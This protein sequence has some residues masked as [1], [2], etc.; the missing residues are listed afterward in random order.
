MRCP[1]A[2]CVVLL[3]LVNIDETNA[4]RKDEFRCRDLCCI[5]AFAEDDRFNNDNFI[6]AFKD[7]YREI[8]I[9]EDKDYRKYCDDLEMFDE[10]V[11][12]DSEKECK[13]KME[14]KDFEV[15]CEQEKGEE[16]KKCF[17]EKNDDGE[18]YSDKMMK[19]VYEMM[20]EG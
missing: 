7:I 20:C 13:N 18:D 9:D 6:K 3:V 16:F 14:D 19:K 4:N 12:D 5:I 11:S 10:I 2:V 17:D 1:I 8:S 15:C